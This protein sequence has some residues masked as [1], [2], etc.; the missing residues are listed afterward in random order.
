MNEMKKGK[1]TDQKVV[2]SSTVQQWGESYIS[3]EWKIFKHKSSAVASYQ[4]SHDSMLDN[5]YVG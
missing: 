4:Y 3:L 1:T 5:C 2:S